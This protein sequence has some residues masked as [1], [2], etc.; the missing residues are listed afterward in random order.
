MPDEEMY[1]NVDRHGNTGAS[2]LPIALGEYLQLHPAEVGDHFLLVAFGGGLTWAASVVRW[3]DVPAIRNV[4]RIANVVIRG[5][6][7][8]KPAIDRILASHRRMSGT[9]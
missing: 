5:K 4:A 2:S 8:T 3:A 1:V 9:K 6:L 7:M